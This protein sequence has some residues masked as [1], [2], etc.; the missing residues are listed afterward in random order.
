ML[1][2]DPDAVAQP[3]TVGEEKGL[4]RDSSNEQQ[5][6]ADDTCEIEVKQ[7]VCVNSNF[8]TSSNVIF[9]QR[10]LWFK[11]KSSQDRRGV[12]KPTWKLLD[13]I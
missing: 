8:K 7:K 9:V 13:F 4:P 6:S 12:E 2:V 1:S 11:R 3:V 10:H 5:I